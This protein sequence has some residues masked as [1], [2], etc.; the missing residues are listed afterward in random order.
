MTLNERLDTLGKFDSDY[1]RAERAEI[2]AFLRLIYE[3]FFEIL[4][5]CWS[6]RYFVRKI[7]QF[8]CNSHHFTLI[9]RLDILKMFINYYERAE[10]ASR[11]FNIFFLNILFFEISISYCMV[12]HIFCWHNNILACCNTQDMTFIIRPD[13]LKKF[14]ELL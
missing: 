10:R 1:E 5:S 13:I 12:N 3:W 2:F 11:I 9:K 7:L 6:I 8:F 14:H 4:K